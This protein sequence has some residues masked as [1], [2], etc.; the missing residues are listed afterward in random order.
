VD[1]KVPGPQASQRHMEW[2]EGAPRNNMKRWV[3]VAVGG[4]IVI[5]YAF[6]YALSA[7]ESQGAASIGIANSV[8]LVGVFVALVAAGFILR[9]ATPQR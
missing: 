4:L 6:F 8:G 2:F 7:A 3:P 9:R 5:A 1:I